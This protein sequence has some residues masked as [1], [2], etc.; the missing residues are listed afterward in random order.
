MSLLRKPGKPKPSVKQPQ[1][2]GLLEFSSARSAAAGPSS[3]APAPAPPPPPQISE[4]LWVD[5]H[6][7]RTSADLAIHKK[8]VEEVRDWLKLADA[9]LQ[10]GLPPTPRMLVLSGPTGSGKS[11]MLR[12]LADELHFEGRCVECDVPA[13][14]CDV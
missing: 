14:E 4:A 10:L 3:A 7:P 2:R 6:A 11:A 12:V 1:Q 9:S 8:K 13:N 5:K